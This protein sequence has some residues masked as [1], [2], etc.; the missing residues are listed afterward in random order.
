LL[1]LSFAHHSDFRRRVLEVSSIR[2]LALLFP[3]TYIT[4]LSALT[5]SSH[6]TITRCLIFRPH[7][8][9]LGR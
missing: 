1:Q 4:S 7:H 6:P 8:V 9:F 2:C 3:S 5:A